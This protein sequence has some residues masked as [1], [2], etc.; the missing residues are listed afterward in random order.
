MIG[1]TENNEQI[2]HIQ[3]ETILEK[4]ENINLIL[5]KLLY[6]CGHMFRNYR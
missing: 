4:K 2:A 3:R 6:L 1:E 5:W